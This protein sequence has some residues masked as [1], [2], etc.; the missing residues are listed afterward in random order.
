MSTTD[1]FDDDLVRR[2]EK[3]EASGSDVVEP[4]RRPDTIVRSLAIGSP[5]DGRYALELARRTGGS[6]EAVTDAST[7]SAIRTIAACEGVF[8]ETAGGV[9]IAAAEQAR[10]TGII[11]PQDEV[12]ALLTGNG[13]KTPEARSFGLPD[14]TAGP[15]RPGL[16]PVIAPSYA[17]FER[18]LEA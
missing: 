7:A 4:V 17:A 11:G 16:A 6:I 1:F 13:L 12:V 15:G 18:W 8:P 5:A 10:A 9:T 14:R 3:G 2:R